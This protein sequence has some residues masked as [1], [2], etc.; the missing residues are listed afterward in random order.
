MRLRKLSLRDFRRFADRAFE[1]GPGLNVVVGDNESGK[2]TIREALTLALFQNA[3][4]SA[5]GLLAHGRWGAAERPAITLDFAVDGQEY[6]LTR[7]LQARANRLETLD[8]ALTLADPGAI[9]ERIAEL[10]GLGNRALF[11]STARITQRDITLLKNGQSIADSLQRTVTGGE[12]DVLASKVVAELDGAIRAMSSRAATRPGSLAVLPAEIERR[13]REA[14]A[15]RR[16]L[17]SAESAQATLVAER[18]ALA[19]ASESLATNDALAK[20]VA[21]RLDLEARLART[22]ADEDRL[23]RR[24]ARATALAAEIARTERDLAGYEAVLALTDDRLAEIQRDEAAA[25]ATA[26]D[27]APEIDAGMSTAQAAGAGRAGTGALVGLGLAALGVAIVGAAPDLLPLGIAL[28]L[29]GAGLAIWALA[30]PRQI[31]Q[32]VDAIRLDEARRLREAAARERQEL[33]AR[34]R[35]RL[36]SA[37]SP[38]GCRTV[39]ELRARRSRGTALRGSLAE[40]RSERR[41][42]LGDDALADVEAARRAATRQGREIREAL[43]ETEMALARDVDAAGYRALQ[44]EIG[45]QTAE[46]AAREARIPELQAVAI[47]NAGGQAE[48]HAVEEEIADLNARLAAAREREAVLKLA[49]DVLEESRV[50]TLAS[51]QEVL[52]RRLGA[53][54]ASL[55][56]GRYSSVSVDPAS[57]A[58]G[59]NSPERAEPV[60]VALGGDLS[61]GTVE[62]VYLA[63]RIALAELLT[64]DRKPPLILDDPFVSFDAA[65]TAAA[66]ALCKRLAA[67]RQIILF[68]KDASYTRHADR[69]VALQ[70]VRVGGES[71]P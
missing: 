11:E 28:L 71:L 12:Q 18:E 4:G 43:A 21:R 7:D 67:E 16:A 40:L 25:S 1:F 39:G 47:A 33:A 38:L 27:E 49:R 58:L 31:G 24:S 48:L 45:R 32:S 30:R 13:E 60:A 66:L 19:L 57:L 29:V 61:Q 65:R 15:K 6:R 54:V 63:A 59:L 34:A 69:V 17:A 42:L 51:S 53:L 46:V 62:G 64:G 9:D 26:G 55:T 37:L 14:D 70:A 8:G 20:S 68:T 56:A 52:E 50:A 2:S 3:R 23:D 44:I 10:L 22:V 36:D 41:G 5:Q 35:E